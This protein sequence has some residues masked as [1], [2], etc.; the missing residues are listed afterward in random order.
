MKNSLGEREFESS[1]VCTKL[2]Y[3]KSVFTLPKGKH[4]ICC[5]A[6][7]LLF[8]ARK[9]KDDYLMLLLKMECIQTF[10]CV[11]TIATEHLLV[12]C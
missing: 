2:M 7:T 8:M 4:A 12:I 10:Y 5:S 1:L 6:V 11:C 3:N 9:A